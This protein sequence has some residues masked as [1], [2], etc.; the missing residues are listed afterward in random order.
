MR[1]QR[2]QALATASLSDVGRVRQIN[3]DECAEFE[4]AAGARLLV[5]ADGMGGHAGGEVASRLAVEAIG[6]SFRQARGAPEPVLR[7]AFEVANQRIGQRAARDPDLFGMGT[8]AV[9]LL[10]EADGSACVAHVGDS[11]AYRLREGQL[12][13]LTDDHSWVFQAVRDGSLSA[14]DAA[15]H[16]QRNALLRS[17]GNEEQVEVDLRR[18]DIAPG[19]RLLLCSDGLWG[20]LDES[21]IAAELAAAGPAP[22]AR[23]LVELANRAGG[24]DNVSVQVVVVG[25]PPRQPHRVRLP[26]ALLAALAAAS[27]AWLAIRC[28]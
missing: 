11:R 26:A 12:E 8:T 25:E 20:E 1:P 15:R 16:P 7:R 18:I 13:R 10:I 27:L 3:Q 4:N 6:E 17:L 14:E 22:C 19:D 9:A 2:P 5:L 21:S 28:A 24:S 23:R